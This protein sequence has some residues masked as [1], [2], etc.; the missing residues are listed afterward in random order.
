M[1]VNGYAF[2]DAKPNASVK[3][4]HALKGEVALGSHVKIYLM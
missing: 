1:K 3:Y 4:L 2:I